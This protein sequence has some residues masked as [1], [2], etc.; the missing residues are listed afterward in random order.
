MKILQNQL[1]YN[2]KNFSDFLLIVRVNFLKDGSHHVRH[3]RELGNYFLFRQKRDEEE[4]LTEDKI[5]KNYSLFLNNIK[6]KEKVLYDGEDGLSS[7]VYIYP[8]P[9][10]LIE[11]LKR[12]GII[13]G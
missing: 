2:K 11:V 8:F 13:K 12:E 10:K 6:L 4:I 9:N 7:F 1:Y 5:I 3:V